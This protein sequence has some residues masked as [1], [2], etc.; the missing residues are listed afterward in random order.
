MTPTPG[1]YRAILA[2]PP[3]AFK[4]Y[5][6]KHTTPH[7]CAED[8]YR[9]MSLVDLKALPVSTWAAP[10]CALFMWAVG[11][12]FDAAMELAN[13][14]GFK[15]KT[16]VFVWNKGKIGMGYWSRKQTETCLLFTKGKPKRLCKGVRQLITAPR[17]EHSRKPDE[18]YERIEALVLGPYLE[19]FARSHRIGWDVWGDQTDKFTTSE[20]SKVTVAA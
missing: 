13:A 16:D 11:S 5:S 3:W 6:G 8:H 14:W 7:R 9:T 12:H 20:P 17:R 18:T 2:D 15:F 1:K 10:D 4:T 19:M